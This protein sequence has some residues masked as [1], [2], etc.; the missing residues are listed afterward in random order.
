MRPEVEELESRIA[1]NGWSFLALF[2]PAQT[3]QAPDVGNSGVVS[4]IPT[5]PVT[6]ALPIPEDGFVNRPGPTVPLLGTT[7]ARQEVVNGFGE[8]LLRS[9]IPWSGPGGTEVG[10]PPDG[11]TVDIQARWP[12]PAGSEVLTP[13][14]QAALPMPAL[15]ALEA[16]TALPTTGRAALEIAMRRFLDEL[17]GITP[18]GGMSPSLTTPATGE[19]WPWL[20]ASGLLAVACEIA[21]RQLRLAGMSPV[22]SDSLPLSSPTTPFEM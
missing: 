5:V 22:E 20:M 16:L 19:L 10:T 2:S 18:L 9:S 15:R 7:R 14:G 8:P 6:H 17:D 21:R 1:L 4:A 13:S 12:A 11:S 3:P